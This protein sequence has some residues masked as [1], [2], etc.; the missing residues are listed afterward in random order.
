M[1]PTRSATI[2]LGPGLSPREGAIDAIYRFT[3]ALD[4][5]D[6]N[7]L[8]SA[9]ANDG[10]VDLSGLTP[11]TGKA[12]DEKDG[13]ESIVNSVLAHVGPMDS[14]HHLS[15]FRV[16]IHSDGTEAEVTC[17]ALAQHFKAGEGTHPGERNY[18][19]MGNSYWADVAR[20][21]SDEDALWKIR[22]IEITN[23]WSEGDLAALE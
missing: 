11:C 18:L 1:N 19:I 15:N 5:A 20:D 3:Q 17:Y 23:M 16:K 7:L 8:R 4:D 14:A 9:F 13:I 12:Y 6:E 2:H 21:G 10:V 22:R